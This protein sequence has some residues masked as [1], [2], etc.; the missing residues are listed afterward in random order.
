[1]DNLACTF[2]QNSDGPY[3]TLISELDPSRQMAFNTLRLL[4][5]NP[6]LRRRYAQYM[7]NDKNIFKRERCSRFMFDSQ[8]DSTLLNRT[9]D[10]FLRLKH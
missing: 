9:T 2:R 5:L 10:L 8:I 3:L 6:V 7:T 1:V 4:S